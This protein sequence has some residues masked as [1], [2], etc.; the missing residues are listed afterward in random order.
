MTALR[1]DKFLWFARLARTRSAAA[2]LC[3]AG[4]LGIRG[5]AALKPHQSVRVGD[6]LT[7]EQGRV[8]RRIRVIALAER[9]GNAM[10]ARDL[11]DEPAPPEL[12]PAEAWTSL[13]EDDL[14]P[15]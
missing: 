12:V 6:W 10:A 3:A 1:L 14:Q 9:R 5:V 13:F 15:V 2:R 11:Y 4:K 8:I 7:L